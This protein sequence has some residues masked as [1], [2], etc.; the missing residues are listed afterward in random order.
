MVLHLSVLLI[1]NRLS[2]HHRFTWCSVMLNMMFNVI[3]PT[4]IKGPQKTIWEDDR[5]GIVFISNY[6]W[7]TV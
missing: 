6:L 7:K 5:C 4:S 1:C 3:K 2:C